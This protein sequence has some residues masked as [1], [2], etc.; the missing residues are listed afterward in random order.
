MFILRFGI[1]HCVAD[2]GV[3][4]ILVEFPD[5]MKLKDDEWIHVKGSLSSI[6][7]QPFKAAIPVLQVKEWSKIEKPNDPYVYRGY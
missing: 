4:G 7:Y 3:F 5:N 2:S 6:Y 1:I